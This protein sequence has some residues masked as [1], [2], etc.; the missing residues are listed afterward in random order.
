MTCPRGSPRFTKQAR[1]PP[2]RPRTHPS[3][4]CPFDFGCFQGP[5]SGRRSRPRP[6]V[7]MPRRSGIAQGLSFCGWLVTPSLVSS[8]FTRRGTCQNWGRGRAAHRR[9]AAAATTSRTAAAPGSARALAAPAASLRPVR[10]A[11]S[12]SLQVALTA[13]HPGGLLPDCIRL[14]PLRRGLRALPCHLLRAARPLPASPAASSP[15]SQGAQA[16]IRSAGQGLRT[17]H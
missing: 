10:V 14:S 4:V 9:P 13:P 2:P 3:A 1:S 5:G 15:K 12:F 8:G 6:H 7:W 16:E 17:S 11:H